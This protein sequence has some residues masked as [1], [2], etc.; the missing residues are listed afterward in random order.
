MLKLIYLIEIYNGKISKLR[1]Q[2]VI[3]PKQ[4]FCHHLLDLVFSKPGSGGAFYALNYLLFY[5]YEPEK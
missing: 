1:Q 3:H 5:L 2:G 4:Q